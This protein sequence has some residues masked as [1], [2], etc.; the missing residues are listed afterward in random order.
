MITVRPVQSARDWDDFAAVYR[1]VYRDDPHALPDEP[2][3]LTILR[4]PN[5]EL[6]QERRF[7]AFVARDGDRPVGRVVAIHDLAFTQYTGESL[8]FFGFYE[9]IDDHVVATDLLDAAA[10][11][12]SVRGLAT[13]AGPFSPSMFYSAGIVVDAQARLPLIGMPH[14]PLYYA[15]QF[16][17]WGLVSM[18]DFYSYRF[19]EP[20]QM[21]CSEKFARHKQLYERVSARSEITFRRM[22]YRTLARD[23]EIIRELYNTTFKDFWGF[24]PLSRPEM[25]DLQKMM[26]PILDP[27]LTLL[28]EYQGKP[29]A[30]FMGIPDANQAMER[31]SRFR[32]R[33]VRDV[34]TLWYVKGPKRT[35][36]MDGVR[37]DMM[38]VDSTCPDRS[39]ASQVIVEMWR[40]IEERGYTRMEGAPVLD[41]SE[42]MKGSVLSRVEMG[43]YRTYRIY[44]RDLDPA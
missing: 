23:T 21:F 24:S 11:W 12:V 19:D 32:F 31:A 5:P 41:D 39:V 10:A 40:R 29:V 30:F 36:L 20:Y 14:N 37:V 43:P 7:Q 42:W 9:A 38:L 35:R 26:L 15:E 6:A 8:G 27:H 3:D 28:A 44:S 33:W 4:R 1:T 16:E 25:R 18:K 22:R 13:M 34:A 2:I 17:K